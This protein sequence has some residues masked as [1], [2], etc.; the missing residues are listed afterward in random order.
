MPY[1]TSGVTSI[2]VLFEAF[3]FIERSNAGRVTDS[4]PE[5][6]ASLSAFET[7]VRRDAEARG[8][9]T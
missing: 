6:V 9:S 8:V 1:L 4:G 3:L 7:W 5:R 2:L